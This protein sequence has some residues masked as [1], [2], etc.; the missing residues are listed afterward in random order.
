[1]PFVR[2]MLAEGRT[3]RERRTIADQV[4]KALVGT[5]KVPPDDRFQTV[6]EFPDADFVWDPSY[7]GIERTSKV[8]FIQ[9]FLN[10]G[11]TIEVKKAL[12][13]EIARL[14]GEDPGLRPEDV[15]VNLVEVT[16]ENW[17]FGGGL[18]SYPPSP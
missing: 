13:A 7:L 2:I 11:R 10:A 18:M 3:P 12:Y 6:H 8:V 16:R 9:I 1:M 4:H 17:S 5:A 14:L 15:L